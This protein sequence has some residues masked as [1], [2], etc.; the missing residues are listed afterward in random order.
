MNIVNVL[1]V[2]KYLIYVYLYLRYFKVIIIKLHC[3]LRR[4]K[5]TLMVKVPFVI[6]RTEETGSKR[7]PVLRVWI[8]SN[9]TKIRGRDK[10]GKL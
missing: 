2:G 8:N 6:M 3:R 4:T 7:T 1:V 5:F 10:R 9:D